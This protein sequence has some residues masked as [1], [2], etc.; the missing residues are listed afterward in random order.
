MIPVNMPLLTEREKELLVQCVET[1]WISS[2]GSFVNAFEEMMAEYVGVKHGVAVS[3]G[4][5]ALELGV[6]ACSLKAGAGVLMPTFTIISCA[7]AVLK[8]GLIPVLVDADPETWCMDMDQAAKRLKMVSDIR[9]VMPVHIYGHPCDMD[10]ILEWVE[11][12][13]LRVV[14]DA[15]EVHGATYRGRQCGSFGHVGVF[16][17]YANK[18]VTTGEGGMCVT[19]DDRLAERMR[20]LR[21]LCFGSQKRF[22]HRQAGY[23][24]RMT[25]LQAAVGVAQ[26]ERIDEL[27][28]RKRRQGDDYRERLEDVVGIRLQTIKSWADPVYWVNSIVIEDDHPMDA[29]QLAAKLWENGVQTRPFFLP[30]HEQPVLRKMGLF[31]GEVYPVAEKLARRGLYLPSGMALSLSQIDEVCDHLK[32]CF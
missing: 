20:S 30:M 11:S 1:G 14:E 4:T 13:G 29:H 12:C 8:A 2:E 16:S 19:D 25:N 7:L 6:V 21:N 26:M 24:Y 17:F 23:N 32:K 22:E 5:A 15:A 27:L 3:S 28:A 18:I 31:K 10:P 9:A